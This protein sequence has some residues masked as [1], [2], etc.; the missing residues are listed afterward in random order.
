MPQTQASASVWFLPSIS[1]GIP[2]PSIEHDLQCLLKDQCFTG[3]WPSLHA[4]FHWGADLC[5]NMA[6]LQHFFCS[7]SHP[8]NKL[9]VHILLWITTETLPSRLKWKHRI[10]ANVLIPQGSSILCWRDTGPKIPKAAYETRPS[11]GPPSVTLLWAECF[12]LKIG[13][14]N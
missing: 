6:K 9:L 11:T 10:S 3:T 1:M 2:V 4:L 8:L 13:L 14:A 12:H 5:L 7:A